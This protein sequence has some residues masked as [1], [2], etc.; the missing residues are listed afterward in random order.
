MMVNLEIFI[1]LHLSV[2][3]SVNFL[4]DLVQLFAG[5]FFAGALSEIIS[6]K[7]ETQRFTRWNTKEQTEIMKTD[8]IF[9][10]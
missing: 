5:D 10:N 3:V 9:P 4:K 7:H 1:Q 6:Q 8:L 2:H